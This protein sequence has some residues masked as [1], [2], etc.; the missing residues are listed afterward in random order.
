MLLLQLRRLKQRALQLQG[1]RPQFGQVGAL[2][3]VLR[4]LKKSRKVLE[5]RDVRLS[6]SFPPAP[7][8]Q[9]QPEQ[10]APAQVAGCRSCIC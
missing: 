10:Q 1:L 9:P 2:E 5:A 3:G 4:P 8:T 6:T 7:S